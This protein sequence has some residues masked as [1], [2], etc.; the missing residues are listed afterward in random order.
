MCGDSM[1]PLFL[2][3]CFSMPPRS[4]EFL[5]L[6]LALPLVLPFIQPLA[7]GFALLWVFTFAVLFA[8]R[9]HRAEFL[10]LWNGAAL[11]S[12]YMVQMLGKWVICSGVLLG[13]TYFYEPALFLQFPTERPTLWMMVLCFYPFLSA[14]PQEVIYRAF[15]FHR[16]ASLFKTPL[17]MM[18]VNAAAF[19]LI[20]VMFGNA[21]AV[22]LSFFGGLLFA[23]TY[24]TSK[25]LALVWLE[26]TLYGWTLF[27]LGLGWYFYHGN[28]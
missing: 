18:L 6:F 13:Y 21:L 16:Y 26:H 23:H 28:V 15:F 5:L 4:L 11:K 1:R 10:L 19:A 27:T 14:L 25:S 22:V 9:K 3:I 12:R 7:I 20:H 8:A 17:S 2:E 24:H